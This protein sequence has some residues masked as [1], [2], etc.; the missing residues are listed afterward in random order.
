VNRFEVKDRRALPAVALTTDSSNLTAIGNDASFETIF[1]RQI[2]ALGAPG[3]VAVG[4]TTSGTSPNVLRALEAA[5]AKGM[6]TIGFLGRD[7]GPARDLCDHALVVE[8]DRTARIQEVHLQIL[9][10]LCFLVDE[11]FG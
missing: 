5:R 6:V 7:G 3:D 9:H 4:I 1:S 11:A 2:E 8:H 10:A